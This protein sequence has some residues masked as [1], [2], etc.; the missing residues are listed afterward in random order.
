MIEM[1]DDGDITSY[2]YDRENRL[3]EAELPDSTTIE[4]EYGPEG[5]RLKRYDGTDT[6]YYVYDGEDVLMELDGSGTVEARYTHVPADAVGG[7]SCESCGG[8]SG[9]VWAIDY[10][11]MMRR[12][13]E[14]YFYMKDKLGSVVG[15]LDDEENVEV[16][17]EYDAW[18]TI[19]AEVGSLWNPYRF[20]AREYDP[21]TG[22]YYY[23]ART[24]KPETGRFMQVDLEGMVD[25]TDMYVYVGNDPGNN[26][27]P[28]GKLGLTY[29]RHIW[30]VAE[31]A[32]TCEALYSACLTATTA[33]YY[34]YDDCLIVASAEHTI[35]KTN[36]KAI[37]VAATGGIVA[38]G[39]AGAI[40]TFGASLAAAAAAEAANAAGYSLCL[41]DC[42]SIYNNEVNDCG[43]YTYVE[44]C[45][46]EYDDCIKTVSRIG[47][48]LLIVEEVQ[49]WIKDGPS[50]LDFLT[51]PRAKE[52]VWEHYFNGARVPNIYP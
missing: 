46:R 38:I 49:W 27:D 28:Y 11:L 18:G 50:G 52:Q 23:R 45:N 8:G 25:G 51:D 43:D 26:V 48:Y 2:T 4:Y 16:A 21:D 41:S 10:P 1:D 12:D 44:D 6:I 30:T 5:E 7:G 19:V 29:P 39:V 33:R 32:R 36:C 42:N 13:S 31:S 17:Y 20:T 40:A 35:C 22:D 47:G 9:S 37:Y 34:S 3:I 15:L 24:Y 14:N